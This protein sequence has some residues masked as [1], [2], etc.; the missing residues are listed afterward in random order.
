[1]KTLCGFL[2]AREFSTLTRRVA[3]LYEAD[4]SAIPPDPRLMPGGEAIRWSGNGTGV[5]AAT[6][7]ALPFLSRRRPGDRAFAQA[8]RGTRH[9]L[10]AGQRAGHGGLLGSHRRHG[11]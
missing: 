5:A 4:P 1:P 7:D 11:L 8:R 2:K 10:A 6:D 9:A 3:E